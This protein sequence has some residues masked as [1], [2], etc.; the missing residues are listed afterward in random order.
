MPGER[1]GMTTLY[2]H[3]SG[4]WAAHNAVSYATTVFCACLAC[5]HLAPGIRSTVRCLQYRASAG[6]APCCATGSGV[7]GQACMINCE[8]M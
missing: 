5:Q 1:P 2:P 7:W 4:S 8:G 6:D 3:T